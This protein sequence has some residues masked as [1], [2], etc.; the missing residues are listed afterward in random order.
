MMQQFLYSDE[1]IFIS[2][3]LCRAPSSF[4]FPQIGWHPRLIRQHGLSHSRLVRQ[5]QPAAAQSLEGV[6]SPA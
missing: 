1:N 5:T 4:W 3:W 6:Y 2:H